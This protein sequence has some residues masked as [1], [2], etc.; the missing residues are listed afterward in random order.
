MIGAGCPSR[1]NQFLIAS[2][3]FGFLDIAKLEIHFSRQNFE[4]FP[5]FKWKVKDI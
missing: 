1:F 3:P 5:T 4:Q 2:M